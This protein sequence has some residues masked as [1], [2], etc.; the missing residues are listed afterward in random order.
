MSRFRGRFPNTNLCVDDFTSRTY[1]DFNASH[2][3]HASSVIYFLSHAHSDHSSGITPSWDLGY[4]YCTEITRALI[5]SKYKGIESNRLIALPLHQPIK[6]AINLLESEYITVTLFDASNHAPGA[7][8]LLFEGYFG[9]ILYTG[10]IRYDHILASKLS[11]HAELLLSS[12]IDYCYMDNTFNH[13]RF[14]SFLSRA[15]CLD[16]IEAVINAHPECD[17]ILNSDLLGKEDI[18]VLLSERMKAL[19]VVA[20]NRMKILNCLKQQQY[21]LALSDKSDDNE[22]ILDFPHW[23]TCFTNDPFSSYIRVFAKQHVTR[24]NIQ[25][26]NDDKN[27]YRAIHDRPVIGILMTGWVAQNNNNNIHNNHVDDVTSFDYTSTEAK[28]QQSLHRAQ[29]F[30][31][32]TENPALVDSTKHFELQELQDMHCNKIGKDDEVKDNQ[33]IHPLQPVNAS[34]FCSSSLISSNCNFP[35]YLHSIPYSSHSS[36]TELISFVQF[37]K[38]RRII[39]IEPS[40]S[41]LRHFESYLDP[42]PIMEC[43]PPQSM[44]QNAFSLNKESRIAFQIP[45]NIST[46][47]ELSEAF[48]RV[49]DSTYGTN[50]ALS[51]QLNNKLGKNTGF[52]LDRNV[53]M[54][55]DEI[56]AL[57]ALAKPVLAVAPEVNYISELDVEV[58]DFTALFEE[59][60]RQAKT[61]REKQRTRDAKVLLQIEAEQREAWKQLQSTCNA[62]KH[63]INCT[64]I[65]CSRAHYLQYLCT[66]QFSFIAGPA[67]KLH[68]RT[69]NN[70]N[71]ASKQLPAVTRL[72]AADLQHINSANRIQS[73]RLSSGRNVGTNV[74]F[75][76]KSFKRNLP[77]FLC[78]EDGEVEVE[79]ESKRIKKSSGRYERIPLIEIDEKGNTKSHSSD[80]H[81]SL[82][83]ATIEL[84]ESDKENS[85]QSQQST[86][87]DSVIIKSSKIYNNSAK[88]QGRKVAF[89]A[90]HSKANFEAE[91]LAES[92]LKATKKKDIPATRGQN[93][94]VNMERRVDLTRGSEVSNFGDELIDEYS[95]LKF[96]GRHLKRDSEGNYSIAKMSARIDLT[97]END[98]R[99]KQLRLDELKRGDITYSKRSRLRQNHNDNQHNNHKPNNPS[100]NTNYN[101]SNN[102]VEILSASVDFALEFMQSL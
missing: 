39:P 64:N 72:N 65:K 99:L 3:S 13:P 46:N 61:R 96:S 80:T 79:E 102:R 2:L 48:H 85:Q 74:S 4:I 91:S 6:L 95:D 45:A 41:D 49:M 22:S 17:V 101:F 10:D 71:L 76:T 37:L 11:Q 53:V 47:A 88:Q 59:E 33:P 86:T 27:E 68:A 84:I 36:F 43:A 24:T 62:Q 90:K 54:R 67:I 40:Y 9:R 56:P 23:Y 60:I 28:Q 82:N 92:P 77:R 57:E 42:S 97:Q 93:T 7:S 98:N 70:N 30:Q 66:S 94:L 21:S 69:H 20:E 16:S 83:T 73:I 31:I 78:S 14:H 55:E 81:H 18:L 50:P 5:L 87:D 63:S 19:I 15:E 38:P 52:L 58:T 1:N 8:M 25:W 89:K 26:M 75:K 12:P 29:L 44:T 51:K 32:L 35:C 34:P 100:K